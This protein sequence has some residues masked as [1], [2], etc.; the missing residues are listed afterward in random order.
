MHLIPLD[1][2]QLVLLSIVLIVAIPATRLG[3]FLKLRSDPSPS[4]RH[5]R[6]RMAVML[7][8]SPAFALFLGGYFVNGLEI[9]QVIG[10]ALAVVC[11]FVYAALLIT[12][13]LRSEPIDD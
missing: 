3:P 7:C 11:I 12:A 10:L 5:K 1:P 13:T 2:H 8:I 9:L 6:L 4:A